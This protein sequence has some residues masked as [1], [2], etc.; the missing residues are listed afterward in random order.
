MSMSRKKSLA[1]EGVLVPPLPLHEPPL[2]AHQGAQLVPFEFLVGLPSKRHWCPLTAMALRAS[3]MQFGAYPKA[4]GRVVPFV[5]YT[6]DMHT[7]QPASRN[8]EEALIHWQVL[9]SFS[10]HQRRSVRR[11]LCL[12]H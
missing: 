12:G 11:S 3:A 5:G 6:P 1:E 7:R 8:P 9:R 4:L 2:Q 10:L